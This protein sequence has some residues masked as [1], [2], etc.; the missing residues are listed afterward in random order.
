MNEAAS[1][2][3]QLT[4]KGHAVVDQ[5]Q[6]LVASARFEAAQMIAALMNGDLHAIAT[7]TDRAAAECRRSLVAI[8]RP[9]QH[10]GRPA[11]EVA[12][13]MP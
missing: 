11:L 7:G 10:V 8:L 2:S 1:Y 4:A 6:A 9:M 3:V 13:P 12:F 5:A